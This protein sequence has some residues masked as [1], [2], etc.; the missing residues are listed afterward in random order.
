MPKEMAKGEKHYVEELRE[1]IEQQRG[2]KESVEKVFAVFCHRHGI[3]MDECRKYYE[4]LEAEGEEKK[5]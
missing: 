1:M 4:K 5:G 2:K 3:S